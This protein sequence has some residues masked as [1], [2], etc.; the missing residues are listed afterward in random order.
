MTDINFF[1][2]A[3]I[4]SAVIKDPLEG[5]TKDRPRKGTFLLSEML[6]FA[7]EDQVSRWETLGFSSDTKCKDAPLVLKSKTGHVMLMF[8]GA[9]DPGVG[10]N[11]EEYA[12]ITDLT[13]MFPVAPSPEQKE[14]SRNAWI[15]MSQET[16]APIFAALGHPLK[17]CEQLDG[18][19]MPAADDSS[20]DGLGLGADLAK[21]LAEIA[22]TLL[23]ND[24]GVEVEMGCF[25]SKDR[26]T[27]RETPEL[28]TL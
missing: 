1:D 8:K 12:P 22:A 5:T 7:P 28:T 20:D 24:D 14:K 25:N 10:T 17:A 23:D 21:V 4:S 6:L 15:R 27:G 9:F 11:G 3:Q 19:L 26:K 13:A 18:R 2:D 16:C